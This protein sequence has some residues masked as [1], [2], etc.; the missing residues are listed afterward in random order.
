MTVPRSPGS[1][2]RAAAALSGVGLVAGLAAGCSGGAS[3]APA[4]SSGL[5]ALS[6]KQILSRAEAAATSAGS[7]HFQSTTQDGPSSI[8]FNDDSTSHGGRQYIT[9]S[10]G[11]Q[12]TVLVVAGNGYVNGNATGLNSFLGL[13]APTAAQMAG[14]WILFTSGDP[15]YQQVVAGVSTSSVLGEITP[16]GALTKTGPTRVDGQSVVGVRGAAPS[17]ADMPPGSKITLYVA[18]SGRT[19]P[20]SVLEGSGSNQTHITLSQWGEHVSLAA[21]PHAIPVPSP[22]S[23]PVIA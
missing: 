10:G 19:L 12:M 13:P 8:V 6:P 3:Q 9:M 15:G 1:L 7:V 20:A 23:P 11:G 4:G 14:Q 22:P 17:S 2:R 16:V 18:A 21:P 5:A